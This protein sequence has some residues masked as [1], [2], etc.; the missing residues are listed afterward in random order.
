LR[1]EDFVPTVWE[2]IPY[3]FVADYFTNIGDIISAFSYGNMNL[4]WSTRT[5][6]V[7]A[8]AVNNSA[9]PRLNDTNPINIIEFGID[10]G[11]STITRRIVDRK[12]YN[13]GFVPSLRFEIPGADSSKWINLAALKNGQRRLTP[14]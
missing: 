9:S 7:K 1:L 5:Q 3:S 10:D 11:S 14:Y 13:G 12:N 4:R 2:L 8:I 6:V